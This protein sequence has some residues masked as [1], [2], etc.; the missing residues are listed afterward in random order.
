MTFRSVFLLST[1]VKAIH[2]AGNCISNNVSKKTT[3]TMEIT[4]LYWVIMRKVS[5]QKEKKE[6]ELSTDFDQTPRYANAVAFET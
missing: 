2:E 5:Y 3:S 6:I 1:L 4:F